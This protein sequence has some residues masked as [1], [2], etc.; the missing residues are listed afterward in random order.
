MPEMVQEDFQNWN[1]CLS[2]QKQSYLPARKWECGRM[3][4]TLFHDIPKEPFRI[5]LLYSILY[6]ILYTILYC[7]L[8]CYRLFCFHLPLLLSFHCVCDFF[9]LKC[10]F[11]HQKLF[12]ETNISFTPDLLNLCN[13]NLSREKHS[14]FKCTV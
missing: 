8:V 13:K 3:N 12:C 6:S 4:P 10:V 9:F 7:T 2:S 5:T 1:T 11:L 14:S